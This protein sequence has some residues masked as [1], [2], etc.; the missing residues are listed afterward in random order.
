[1]KNILLLILVLIGAVDLSANAI[2]TSIVEF[3][4]VG[5][6]NER[7]VPNGTEVQVN[8]LSDYMTNH[9]EEVINN[10]GELAPDRRRQTLLFA[11]SELMPPESYLQFL[12]KL[13][14]ALQA[15]QAGMTAKIVEQA[16]S[17]GTKKMGF[18]AFNFENQ[19]VIDL[20]QKAKEVLPSTSRRQEFL[21][22]ILS[23]EQRKQIGAVL[24]ME[25][26]PQPETLSASE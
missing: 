18:L 21:T 19:T 11:V 14:D 3:I 13:V 6:V 7:G 23:G 17:A 22:D 2:P 1:M 4:E 25:N 5:S 20:C 9:L 12:D 16:L 10:F 24:A 26:L 15:E 8:E